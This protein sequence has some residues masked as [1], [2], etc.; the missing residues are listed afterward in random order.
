MISRWVRELLVQSQHFWPRDKLTWVPLEQ[1]TDALGP[2]LEPLLPLL[3]RPDDVFIG[4]GSVVEVG[5]QL[6]GL[7][8]GPVSTDVDI[9]LLSDAA[10]DV[11][12]EFLRAAAMSGLWTSCSLRKGGIVD[13]ARA[14]P[15]KPWQ[16]IYSRLGCKDADRLTSMFDLDYVCTGLRMDPGTGTLELGLGKGTLLSWVTCCT[17][18]V[19][20]QTLWYARVQ[21]AM[22]KGFSVWHKGEPV[23]PDGLWDQY[24]N[25]V[26]LTDPESLASCKLRTM[27]AT[28]WAGTDAEAEAEAEAAAAAAPELTEPEPEAAAED[29]ATD[30][31]GYAAVLRRF[32]ETCTNSPEPGLPCKAESEGWILMLRAAMVQGLRSSVLSTKSPMCVYFHAAPEVF[33]R[34]PVDVETALRAMDSKDAGLLANR[35]KNIII[36][37]A[38]C[39]Q[40]PL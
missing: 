27:V 19:C 5:M 22:D 39:D 35:Y 15:R 1:G 24:W 13:V 34:G 23:T 11:A 36:T 31:D 38:R 28:S 18:V 8:P 26:D 6:L 16:F 37:L 17:Q 9:F 30:D 4:G 3:A 2:D 20:T 32:A 29:T 33:P 7:G 10:V 12:Q 21:K 25:F 14:P 40:C